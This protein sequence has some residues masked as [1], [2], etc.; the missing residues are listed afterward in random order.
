M[1]IPFTKKKVVEEESRKIKAN[2]PSL[3]TTQYAGNEI[4]TSKYNIIT[5]LPKNLF[6]QFRRLANAYFLFLLCLQLIPQISSLA[7]ITTIL[8]LVFVLA[9][10][11]IKDASDDI[12][13][14][15]SDREVN[16]RETKTVVGKEFVTKKWKD[17][18]VGDMIQLTNNEFVTAD[19]VIISSSDEN[20]LCFIE[21]AELDGET[22]LKVRQALEETCKIG[23]DLNELSSFDAEIEYEAPNNNL[24]RFEGNLTW[25]GKTYPLKNDNVL[26]R[27]T[28]LRNT[29]W[30]FG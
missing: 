17:V 20:G 5:F 30:A 29:Q 19:V 11:A 1:R 2:D 8:P 4:T 3:D 7:P 10:T 9:L 21:T 25:K 24:G 28:R 22:N 18:K 14:H 6:E 16:N 15:R 12:A 23:E 13:R 26:L 27:G